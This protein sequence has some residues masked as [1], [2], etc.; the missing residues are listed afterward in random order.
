MGLIA[1]KTVLYY[2]RALSPLEGLRLIHESVKAFGNYRGEPLEYAFDEQT[3]MLER[4]N[5][6]MFTDHGMSFTAKHDA[7]GKLLDEPLWTVDFN[8]Y[9]ERDAGSELHI[10]P[11]LYEKSERSVK[12]VWDFLMYAVPKFVEATKPSL[13]MVNGLDEDEEEFEELPDILDLPED[14]L[15]S[16]FTPWV[17]LG[18]E[19]LNPELKARLAKLPAYK[20]EAFQDGWIIQA[21]ADYFSKPSPEFVKKLAEISGDKRIA[22]KQ[23]PVD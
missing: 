21:V 3:G 16:F 18:A 6:E 20:S 19:F 5:V 23:T 1:L 17:Y 7:S 22:Y 10:T 13:A 2:R 12:L 4:E 9:G 11:L 14:S 8:F 15:P